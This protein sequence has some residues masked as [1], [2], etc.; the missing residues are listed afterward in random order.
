M[1][2]YGRSLKL[3][4]IVAH[5]GGELFLL[6]HLVKLLT[7]ANIYKQPK[8]NWTHNNYELLEPVYIFMS[9]KSI[10]GKRVCFYMYLL[11]CKYCNEHY[12]YIF[13]C[14]L[15]LVLFVM[16]ISF[17][18]CIIPIPQKESIVC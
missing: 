17:N 16:N 14:C 11:K 3:I 15:K 10:S 8:V 12:I 6:R 5:E 18:N 13:I 4:N 2:M 7:M 1:N 9:I